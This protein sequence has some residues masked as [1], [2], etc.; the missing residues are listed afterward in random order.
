MRGKGKRQRD[1][2]QAARTSPRAGKNG[3]CI[4][5]GR[6]PGR[7]D[8]GVTRMQAGQRAGG[9]EIRNEHRVTFYTGR[10]FVSHLM[11]GP[12]PR[13]EPFLAP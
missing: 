9:D 4:L 5:G 11:P 12:A 13:R 1:V 8:A 10:G 2:D 6:R 3:G 7:L